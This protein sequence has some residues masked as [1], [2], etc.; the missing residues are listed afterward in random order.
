MITQEKPP[1]DEALLAHYGVRGMKWGVRKSRESSDSVEKQRW[2]PEE[3]KAMV[4]K[5]AI[6]AGVLAVALG[7]AYLASNSGKFS[8]VRIDDIKP[9]TA[10]VKKLVE[11]TGEQTD[12][13]HASRTKNKGF[14]FVKS[15][16]LPSPLSEYE[17]V[18]GADRFE[19]GL[20]KLS[21]GRVAAAFHDFNGRVDRAGRVIPH[22]VIIPKAMASDVS[23]MDDVKTKI[24]PQLKDAYDGLYDPD[25]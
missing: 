15:G 1:L 5:V 4:K 6:G 9:P 18:F 17:S 3:K 14:Q 13:F 10:P 22:Q 23:N 12:I 11:K 24:W 20:K 25:N 21:D 7:T 19:P 8:N 16:G 2:T